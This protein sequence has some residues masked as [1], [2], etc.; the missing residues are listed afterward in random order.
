MKVSSKELAM[1]E[2]L[3]WVILIASLTMVFIVL[4][5]IKFQGQEFAEQEFH[6]YAREIVTLIE[7][8]LNDHEQILISGAALFDASD[9][10]ERKEWRAFIRRLNLAKEYPGILGVGYSVV[11]QPSEL[12]KHI[13]SMQAKGFPEYRVYPEGER[14]LYTSIIYLE[15][16]TGRNLAAFGYDMLSQETRAK[17]MYM[18]AETGETTISGKVTLVQETHGRIQAG[19]LMYVPIYRKGYLLETPAQR[20]RALQ[21]YVYSP[22][23][24]ND[25]MKGILGEMQLKLDFDL[26]DGN[27]VSQDKQMYSTKEIDDRRNTSHKP[28]F[29]TIKPITAYNHA[30]TLRLSSRPAF[31][32]SFDTRLTLIVLVLGLLISFLLFFI[33]STLISRRERAIKL[34][35]EMTIKIR[36]NEKNLRRSEERFQLAVRGSNDGIWDWNLLTNEIY[37]S[38]RYRELLGYD[39][40]EFPDLLSSFEDAV[41]PDDHPR[42]VLAINEHLDS[43]KPYDVTF[44]MRNR[45]GEW[46]WIRGKGEAVRDEN[47][48]AVR[49]AG[50]ISDISSQKAAESKLAEIAQHSQ[51]ILDN[52][53]DGI[54]TVDKHFNILSVNVAAENMFGYQERR[55]IGQDIAMLFNGEKEVHQIIRDTETLATYEKEVKRHNGD[56]FNMELTVSRIGTDGTELFIL[57]IRDI[58]ARK[59]VEKLKS[60]FVSTVSHELRT[61]LTSIKGALGLLNSGAT[62]HQTEQSQMLLD[63]AYRNTE[64]LT[65]LINDLLDMEKIAAGQM[66]FDMRDELVMEQVKQAIEASE[67][68]GKLYR[69]QARLRHH[70]PGVMAEI[71]AQR[72]QQVMSNLLSNAIKFSPEDSIV[73]VDV[74][75]INDHVKISVIDHG[76]GVPDDFRDRIF[77]KFSQAD[78]SDTR[79]KGGAGLGLAISRE[80]IEHMNGQIGFNN[81][82]SQGANFFI[83]LPISAHVEEGLTG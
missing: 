74:E 18:A 16:F 10:V 11:I 67:H 12:Q 29:T 58:T 37:Y 73:Y 41:H 15:P 23:R 26:F 63:T 17:A 21:G 13:Q 46:L 60:E 38:P 33:T 70:V 68:Y 42:V 39:S 49:M 27:T 47:G 30:W 25:L 80:L 28:L 50:S 72:F 20:R 2:R 1:R 59:R 4:Y 66:H 40:S 32:K 81:N 69:V 78:S 34:A 83:I 61:P 36:E 35:E 19:F 8:R 9:Q 65:K 24:M 76:P 6:L 62:G 64:R 45:A 52:I 22:Y 14:P 71:D 43:G 51:T 55:I 77:K 57:V 75:I 44:R 82:E 53:V 5:V 56:L 54:I 48:V 79:Q 3:P 7:E 31:E